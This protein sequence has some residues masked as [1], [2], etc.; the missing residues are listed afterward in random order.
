MS[1]QGQSKKSV[2]GPGLSALEAGSDIP[3]ERSAEVKALFR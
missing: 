1:V 3:A 2:F